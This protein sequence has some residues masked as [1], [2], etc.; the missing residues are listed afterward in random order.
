M[1]LR[2]AY[3]IGLMI[4]SVLADFLLPKMFEFG[5]FRY[6]LIVLGL[7]FILFAV[8]LNTLAG[9]TLKLYGHKIKTQK[10]TPPDKFVNIGIF[11][12]M[13]HPGQ[14]GNLFLLFGI[15]LLSAKITAVLFSGWIVF[16]GVLFILFVEEREAIRKFGEDYCE[17]MLKTPPF[18]LNFKCIFSSFRY[19]K[20]S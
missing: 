4:L 17:Y 20:P 5:V 13:R 9:R 8:I 2:F 1:K 16:L 6:V 18:T 7:L 11:S 12:C 15:S 3:W 14:F 19:L 10:F